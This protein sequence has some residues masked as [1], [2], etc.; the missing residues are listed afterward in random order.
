MI[1]LALALLAALPE[2]APIAVDVQVAPEEVALGDHLLVRIAVDHDARDVYALP[3]A[4]PAA[5]DRSRAARRRRARREEVKGHARTVFELSL[6]DYGSL[7]PRLP[8]LILHVT[9]PD[10]E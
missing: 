9:G 6:A 3:V 2:A 4:S 10:G 8:D 5:P 7:E 1:A